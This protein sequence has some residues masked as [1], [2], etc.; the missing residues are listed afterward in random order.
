MIA[1]IL[2][3][4]GRGS[5]F[6]S[7]KQLATMPDGRTMLATS[8]GNLRTAVSQMVIVVSDDAA[9]QAHAHAIAREIDCQ[10]VINPRADEG[11]GTSIACGVSATLNA[12]GWLIALADMPFIQQNTIKSV[13]QALCK[14]RGIV[15]P[16]YRD[17]RGHPVGFDRAFRHQLLALLG[18]TGARALINQHPDQ[19]TMLAV[20]D[21][22][23]LR[24]IDTRSALAS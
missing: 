8:A 14:H 1:G 23:V 16:T 19:L 10:I 5:R 12:D 9:L 11:M 3:A 24:D 20:E 13:A 2:L 6:G 4:A 15:L 21:A 18:D 7:T 17:T 22:G